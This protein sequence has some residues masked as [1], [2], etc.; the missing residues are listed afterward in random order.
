MT[1]ALDEERQSGFGGK[2]PCNEWETA[3]RAV[4]P[5][6]SAAGPRTAGHRIVDTVAP[7]ACLRRLVPGYRLR[8]PTAARSARPPSANDS[9]RARGTT[10][11]GRPREC[12]ALRVMVTCTVFRGARA[13]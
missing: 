9:D 7:A 1:S 2:R 8:S 5:L 12:L 11:A 3:T 10:S 13:L 4:P 6:N